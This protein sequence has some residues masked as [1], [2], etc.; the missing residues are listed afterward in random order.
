MG[1]SIATPPG[2]RRESGCDFARATASIRRDSRMM[3]SF[4]SGRLDIVLHLPHN[5][6]TH[7][8]HMYLWGGWVAE[9]PPGRG[10][11]LC[12]LFPN[13]ARCKEAPGR[14]HVRRVPKVPRFGG[15]CCEEASIPWF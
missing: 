10:R 7:M 8:S 15:C 11:A 4:G 3:Q 9:K 13:R 6:D 14:G 5:A 2:R 12:A 1:L